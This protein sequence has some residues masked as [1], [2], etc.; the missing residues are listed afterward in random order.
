[1]KLY[2]QKYEVFKTFTVF[3]VSRF[4]KNCASLLIIY[5]NKTKESSSIRPIPCKMK[6]EVNSQIS[7]HELKPVFVGSYTS[8]VSENSG[9]YASVLGFHFFLRHRT[10]DFVLEKQIVI[11]MMLL[12][13]IISSELHFCSKKLVQ[14]CWQVFF[15]RKYCI[16]FFH[17]VGNTI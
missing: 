9:Q 8:K 14:C 1:M 10:R 17:F 11:H 4:Y 13:D 7:K 5:L 6:L 2:I 16:A 15:E 12:F 3:S